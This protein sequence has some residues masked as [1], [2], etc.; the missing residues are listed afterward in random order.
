MPCRNLHRCQDRERPAAKK[1]MLRFSFE[2]HNPNWS[3]SVKSPFKNW[4]YYFHPSE[5]MTNTIAN[6]TT[7]NYDIYSQL[8]QLHSK[9]WSMNI[10]ELSSWPNDILWQT[11]N[12]KESTNKLTMVCSLV[13]SD[14]D[15]TLFPDTLRSNSD[16]GD[17]CTIDFERERPVT[18]RLP[19]YADIINLGLLIISNEPAFSK[20]LSVW[21]WPQKDDLHVTRFY[22]ADALPITKLR[23]SK[24]SKEHNAL[25][26]TRKNES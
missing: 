16:G 23:V 5:N 14:F 1:G 10:L 4:K 25:T 8:S 24:Y 12:G 17:C 9:N 26:P 21:L 19:W 22:S 2:T 13:D 20:L 6:D 3:N 15:R 11:V 18:K 7:T